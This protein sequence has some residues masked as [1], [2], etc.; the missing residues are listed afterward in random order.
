M[1]ERELSQHF[2]QD[3]IV[4]A[5]E[6]MPNE[7][8]L[9]DGRGGFTSIL[10]E[11]ADTTR[12][13]ATGDFDGD[14]SARTR[15]R[16]FVICDQAAGLPLHRC[17]LSFLTQVAVW[18]SDIVFANS[19]DLGAVPLGEPAGELAQHNEVLFSDG[20][21]GFTSTL[22]ERGDASV[23]VATGDFDGNGVVRP[24]TLYSARSLRSLTNV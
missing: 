4:I 5:Y 17:K 9:A 10:L 16:R 1:H 13:V 21:G 23:D 19:H 11:R 3:D 15:P 8:L 22:L 2:V 12:A 20:Q 6:D 7:V 14:G 24:L 18:Q